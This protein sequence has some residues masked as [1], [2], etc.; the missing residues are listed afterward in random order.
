MLHLAGLSVSE[1]S[2][3][4]RSQ[5]YAAL[6]SLEQNRSASGTLRGLSWFRIMNFADY[7]G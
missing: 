6:G 5:A 1:T 4:R 2:R 7:L 3:P